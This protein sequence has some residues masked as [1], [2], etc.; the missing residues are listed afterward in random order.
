MILTAISRHLQKLQKGNLS[1][2][3]YLGNLRK[4][5]RNQKRRKIQRSRNHQNV[6]MAFKSKTEKENRIKKRPNQNG[7][8]L[9]TQNLSD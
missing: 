4:L 5:K 8:L 1:I 9:K 3:N 2:E 7:R 6:Q